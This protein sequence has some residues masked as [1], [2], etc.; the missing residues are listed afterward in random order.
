MMLRAL[1]NISEKTLLSLWYDTV[2]TMIGNT[3]YAQSFFQNYTELSSHNYYKTL[4]RG[5]D[6]T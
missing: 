6:M 4:T 3:T 2:V 5:I 1:S